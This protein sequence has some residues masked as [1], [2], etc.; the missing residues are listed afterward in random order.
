MNPAMMSAPDP[1]Q[2]F[3]AIAQGQMP[4][5]APQQVED[6]LVRALEYAKAQ[7]AQLG[8][9]PQMDPSL[10][11][12]MEAA[13]RQRQMAEALMNQGYVQNSGALG[14]LAQIAS[15]WKGG[16]MDQEA[17]ESLS[18]AYARQLAAEQESA[19]YAE[20]VKAFEEG[21]AKIMRRAEEAKALGLQGDEAKHFLAT[22]TLPKNSQKGY[23]MSGGFLLNKDTG[24]VEQVPGYEQ[25]RA[26]IA[27]AGAGGGSGGA[28]GVLSPEEVAQMG[29]PEG[30][31]VQRDPKG[32][33]SVLQRPPA[34]GSAGGEAKPLPAEARM[35]LGMLRAAREALT[36]YEREVL[37]EGGGFNESALFIGPGGGYMDEAVNNVLRVESGA[38]VPE[39]ET[40]RGIARYGAGILNQESTARANAQQLRDKIDILE[41]ELTGQDPSAQP[42]Q[43]TIRVRSIRPASP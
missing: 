2:A 27:A 28:Y 13:Q 11:S 4:P 36:N 35:K 14:A 34:P 40:K 31:V 18:D 24:D 41:R 39:E 22:G 30:T 12:D 23:Q 25:S 15:A 33:L 37:P 5:A 16:K 26:R 10:M 7:Q 42:Q 6:P 43:P 9:A 19:R 32:K 38:A 3:A 8:Q 20:Q 21:P 1:L 29:L 17:G